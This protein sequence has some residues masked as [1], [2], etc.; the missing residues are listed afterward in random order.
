MSADKWFP[1][2]GC[3][4]RIWPTIVTGTTEWLRWSG[5]LFVMASAVGATT[6]LHLCLEHMSDTALEFIPDLSVV[7]SK[8][9]P[10]VVVEVFDDLEGPPV[11]DHIPT[12]HVFLQS[13]GL[14]MVTGIAK[15]LDRLTE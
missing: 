8:L 9:R 7:L 6:L 11:F 12:D 14:L 4:N 15:C 10:V 5:L 1:A 13:V 3:L 2:P